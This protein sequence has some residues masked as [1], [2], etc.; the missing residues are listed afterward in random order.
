MAL[1]PGFDRNGDCF[2]SVGRGAA[3]YYLCRRDHLLHVNERNAILNR[4]DRDHLY[5]VEYPLERIPYE[6]FK[7]AMQRTIY[8]MDLNEFW[9]VDPT[10]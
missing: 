10:P 9:F 6:E 4:L 8:E 5:Y 3:H 7:H 2:K 1:P